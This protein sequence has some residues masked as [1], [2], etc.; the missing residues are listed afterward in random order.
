MQALETAAAL[1]SDF[2]LSRY[3]DEHLTLLHGDL[4]V[5]PETG[6]LES[7]RGIGAIA[8][9]LLLGA[10]TNK[11]DGQGQ[12]EL[13]QAVVEIN[14]NGAAYLR[15]ANGT[16][17]LCVYNKMAHRLTLA[18]DSLG[19]R[20]LYYA[21]SDGLLFFATSIEALARIDA[22]P[23]TFDV[24]TYI[25]EEAFC[26]PLGC[27]TMYTG[28][29]VVVANEAVA[30]MDGM[31]RTSRYF[32]WAI[33]PL[34]DEPVDELAAHCRFA[35]RQAVASRAALGAKQTCLLSGGLDSR[36]VV[37][38]LLELG[39]QTEGIN[40]AP[41]GYQDDV[42]ARRFAEV[43]HIP[44]S[45]VSWSEDLVGTSAAACTANLLGTAV[46]RLGACAVFTG[47]GGGETFGFLVMNAGAAELLNEGKPHAAVEEYLSRYAVSKYL[48][49][50]EALAQLRTVAA[51]RM[52]AELA[53][54]GTG[55]RE[56]ALHI[57]VLTN[58]LRCHLHEYF[59]RLPRTRVELLLPF[60]DRRV[61]ESVLRIPPPVAP[62]MKHA[63]YHRM[64]DLL[65][66]L[67]Q[68]VPWQTYPGHDACPLAEENPPPDQWSRKGRF[69]NALATRCLEMAL[70]PGFPPV[71][72]RSAVLAAVALHKARRRDFTY[73]FKT[74]INLHARCGGDARW[75]LRE[76]GAAPVPEYRA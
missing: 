63:F 62:L 76:D 5:L 17:A 54:I 58:D 8:G 14:A 40:V 65:P 75:V 29:R 42:Y 57:F 19:A 52:A 1:M 73:L 2:R 46:S 68:A 28:I 43:A 24:A 44:L 26:Y 15:H 50:P 49:K 61:I 36:V 56:K 23:K 21:V 30:A 27:R 64:L 48:F 47:D 72:R 45:S 34:A 55:L 20:P 39:H 7:D 3:E 69:G 37:A 13:D 59:N 32:D 38:E 25:E 51:D 6:W 70:K 10:S 11:E 16:F 4:G 35:L 67:V 12:P 33:L 53:R 60:Y 74:C 22:V 71:L 18:G 41:E 9:S 66:P 31:V